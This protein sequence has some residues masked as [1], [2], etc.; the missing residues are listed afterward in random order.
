MPEEA[1]LIRRRDGVATL[2]LNRP[3]KLNAINAALIEGLTTALDSVE[4]DREIRVAV[5]TG[6][7]RGFCAGGDIEQMMELKTGFHSAAF[8]GFLEAGHGLV[9]KLRTLPKPVVASV[10]G[11]AAGGGVG[12]ALAC[13]L[14]I[15]SERATFTQAFAKLGLHP[16]WGGSFNLPR[17]VGMGRALEMFWL[18]EPVRAEEAKRLGV[19]NFL[20]PHESLAD[21]TAQLSAR[22]A[23]AAPLPMA[24]MKQAFYER[25]HTELERVMDHEL[26][27]QMKCFASEDV[28]EGLRAFTEKRPPKFKGS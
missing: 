22:L 10:N 19:I 17:L 21:E 12:L 27:A 16:D 23:A 3:E 20:V 25:I 26:E 18:S 4:R 14:R 5:I 2:V 28:N 8:R 6:A 24:L 7:G 15:A 11:P 1:V 9:R 13:D